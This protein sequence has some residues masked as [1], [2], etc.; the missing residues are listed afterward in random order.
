MAPRNCDF[1]YTCATQHN[2]SKGGIIPIFS[3]DFR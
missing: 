3:V 1:I 2:Y